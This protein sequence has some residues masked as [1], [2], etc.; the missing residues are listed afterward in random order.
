MEFVSVMLTNNPRR[1]FGMKIKLAILEK[2]T[3]YLNRIVTVFSTKYSD[4]FQIYS[5]SEA[6]NAFDA[7]ESEKI[8]VLIANDAFDIDFSVLPKRCGF[9]Y[10]VDSADID[11]FNGQTAICKYQKAELI[12][13]QILSLYSE[14]AGNISGVKISDDVCQ[15]V[16]FSSPAGGTGTSTVAAAYAINLAA[17]QKRVMYLCVE[18]FGSADAY[19]DAE[20]QFDMSDVIFSIKSRKVNL[21]MK[22]DSYVK[23]DMRGVSFYSQPKYALDMIEF[24]HSEKMQLIEELRKKGSYD[25]IVLDMHFAL[26]KEHF[27]LYKQ[28]NAVYMVS[29]GSLLSNMKTERAFRAIMTIDQNAEMPVAN[30]FALIYNRF[31]SKSGK[32]LEDD[33]LKC[34]GGVPVFANASPSQIA[35]QIAARDVFAEIE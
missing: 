17:K 11:T 26:D 33:E 7:L 29:D 30:R 21:A 8:D 22:L 12:Y 5:F 28:A 4:K 31:S 6:A 34:I 18:D 20:G 9:A 13:K 35:D 16:C 27:E 25:C 14:H 19:F 10:F 3:G 2:D 15:L 24:R 1:H 23:Q 32:M